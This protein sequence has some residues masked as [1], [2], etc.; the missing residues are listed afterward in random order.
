MHSTWD[1]DGNKH[2]PVMLHRALLG[3]FERFIGILIENYS[4][5]LPF[6]LAPRQIVVATI[7][8]E[9]DEYAREVAGALRKAGLRAE[10]DTRNEKIN[11]KVREHSLAKV[12]VIFAVGA[13]E[14]SNGTVSIRKLGERGLQI[15]N[16]GDAV[17]RF[18]AEAM[19]PDLRHAA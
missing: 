5:K 11:F 9:A 3:S 14:L 17:D 19:P 10:A 13:K 1:A 12:P 18:A 15:S 8:S 16:V 2:R 4:G 6:W 7:V